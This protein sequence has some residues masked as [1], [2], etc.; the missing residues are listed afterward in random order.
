MS[1]AEHYE[2]ISL[3][4]Q[5]LAH[6]YLQFVDVVQSKLSHYLP[7][8][9]SLDPLKIQV[10]SLVVKYMIRVFEMARHALVVDGHDISDT[11]VRDLLALTPSEELAP[12]DTELNQRLR[13]LIESVKLQTTEV[14]RLRRELPQQAKDAYEQL[15]ASTDAEVTAIYT[16]FKHGQEDEK[17]D[18]DMEAH[19]GNGVGAMSQTSDELE[20]VDAFFDD[21]EA[22]RTEYSE[23][24]RHLRRLKTELPKQLDR[25]R[26]LNHTLDFMN[27]AYENQRAEIE[28]RASSQ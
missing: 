10:E 3:T 15:V 11:S 26:S 22:I 13:L 28:H 16:D 6:V 27:A 25:L 9:D 24:I 8:S 17:E 23:G 2:K 4:K 5:E 21:A 14:T 7:G 19:T 12:F 20:D 18:T 1:A